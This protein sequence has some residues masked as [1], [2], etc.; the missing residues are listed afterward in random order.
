MKNQLHPKSNFAVTG[1]YFYDNN[2]VSIAR[3][4]KPS[5]RGELEITE[6][7]QAY[8]DRGE[9]QIIQLGRGFA[10]FDSGTHNSL[11]EASQFVQ[12]IEYRQ[13]QKI[14]CLEEIAYSKGWIN[15]EEL[16]RRNQQIQ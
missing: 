7:N 5:G 2:V 12:L 1:L 10:W 14:A 3:N 4:L 15:D 6:V 16:I 8:L 11:L 13:G 9:L